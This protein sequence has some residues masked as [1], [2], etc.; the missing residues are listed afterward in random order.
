MTQNMKINLVP[1]VFDGDTG[2]LLQVLVPNV[3]E[4]AVDALVLAVD[5][6]LSEHDDVLGV[7]S[8]VGDLQ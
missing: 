5:E 8:P 2:Q 3:D 6:Q 7:T 4:D 1:H